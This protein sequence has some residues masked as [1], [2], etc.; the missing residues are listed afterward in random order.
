MRYAI[1][2]DIHSNLNAFRAVID[3]L[4]SGGG[5]QKIWCL[6]DIVGYG[7]E[8]H[9]CIQLLCEYE[10][11]CVAGNHDWACI[12]KISNT[13]FNPVAAEACE[14]T[15]Q[16]LNTDE[17]NYLAGLPEMIT[18][19]DFTLVH[20]SPRNPLTEY[21]ISDIDAEQN[22]SYFDTPY[23]LIGHSHVPMVFEKNNTVI[24]TRLV[25][26]IPVQ[27]GDNRLI[28]NPGG[29][30]QPRDNDPRAAYAVYDSDLQVIEHFRVEYDVKTT[31][32]KMRQAGLP[33]MLA[34]RLDYGR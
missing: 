29:V 7:P 17:I 28:L 19:G 24:F 22:L 12:G 34:A 4:N 14:W 31:Q 11:L 13:I 6:G 15:E 30:G 16:Q 8:P 10:H 3:D 21:L 33:E 9:E 5:F 27:L 32:N 25:E 18:E 26:G 2:A 23:C 20:G 1:L